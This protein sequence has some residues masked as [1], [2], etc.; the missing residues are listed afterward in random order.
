VGEFV[1]PLRIPPLIAQ[2]LFQDL[3]PFQVFTFM[4]NFQVNNVGFLF[5]S[6][7][8]PREPHKVDARAIFDDD[9]F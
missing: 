3:S 6:L 1:I 4:E 9:L 8:Y 2:K 5:L 7:T